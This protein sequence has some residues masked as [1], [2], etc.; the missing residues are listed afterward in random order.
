MNRTLMMYQPR[1]HG[2]SVLFVKQ[3]NSPLNRVKAAPAH[4]NKG[5]K[6]ARGRTPT[7]H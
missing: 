7:S 1:W 4:V 5:G 2:I 3:T 6:R